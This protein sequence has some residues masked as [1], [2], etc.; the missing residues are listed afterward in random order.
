[1]PANAMPLLSAAP[2]QNLLVDIAPWLLVLA[3]LVIVGVLI[4]GPLR[5][6]L[7]RKQSSAPSLSFTLHDLKSMRDAGKL[8]DEE[9]E[10]AAARLTHHLKTPR[11]AADPPSELD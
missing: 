7:L 5:K 11:Q 8:S 4:T 3:G 6:Q 9:F 10:R 1:M 2:S